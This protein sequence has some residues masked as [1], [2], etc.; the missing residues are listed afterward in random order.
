[1][2]FSY[3]KYLV[4]MGMTLCIHIS[5]P[6]AVNINFHLFTYFYV[7][8]NKHRRYV[9]ALAAWSSGIVSAC[10]VMGREI[11]IPRVVVLNKKG[12]YK[13]NIVLPKML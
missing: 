4:K 11:E 1:M 6:H 5:A 7:S 3:K 13:I 2:F 8:K 12:V 10:G 9:H